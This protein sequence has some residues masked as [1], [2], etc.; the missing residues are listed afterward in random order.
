MGR[1]TMALGAAAAAALAVTGVLVTTSGREHTQGPVGASSPASAA[2]P[3]APPTQSPRTWV[4][5]PV[6]ARKGSGWEVPNPLTAVQAGWLPLVAEH[7]DPD[8]G[9]LA[10]LDR[11]PGV[12]FTWPA[13]GTPYSYTHDGSVDLLTD[14]GPFEHGCR[15]LRPPPPV[16]GTTS[17]HTRRLAGPHGERARISRY[18]RLCG[19]FD[20]PAAAY[21]TCGDYAVALAVERRDG[22]IGYL[23]MTGRGTADR[24]PLAPAAMAA[25]AADPRLTLPDA[26][27]AVPSSRVARTVV[28]DHFPRWRADPGAPLL[29]DHPGV[30][31]AEG[32]L[33]PYAFGM[34]VWLAGGDPVCGRTWLV[35]CVE[36][37]VFGADDPTTVFVGSWDEAE[38]AD[39]CPRHS[40]AVSRRF[41][42]VGPRHTVTAGMYRIVPKHG[43]GIGP[44]LDRRMIDLLLDPRLQ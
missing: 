39:C 16:N 33:G 1:R 25:A 14:R 34:T 44:E 38:W 43:A 10:P 9:R 19:A 20:G 15:Y 8:G 17:C 35:L 30:A 41:V 6:A 7:L 28:S 27:R 21:A 31:Y 37:H 22:L 40:R 29:R 23:V 11:G 5:T 32:M 13:G 3:S 26:A 18:Q 12:A 4:D 24:N 42:Y 2:P 36:R